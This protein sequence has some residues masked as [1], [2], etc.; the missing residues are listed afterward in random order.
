MITLDVIRKDMESQL[1]N[2]QMLQSVEVNADSLDEALADAAA[3]LDSRV[4][5]LEYEVLEKGSNGFLG[6][7]KKPW[8][9]R[10]YQNAAASEK[11]KKAAAASIFDDE[12][13]QEE[14]KIVDRD[15][16]YYIRH[17]KNDICI[18]VLLPIGTGRPV[19]SKSVI[20]DARRQDTISLD[21]A[22][23]KELSAAGTNDEY[24]VVGEYKNVKAGDA[25]LAV[26]ITKDEMLATITVT[27]PAMSGSELSREQILNALEV[28]GVTAGIEMDKID[29]FVD[30]PTYNIPC[31]VAAA[32]KPVDGR[33]AYIAFNFET[34]PTK[35][36]IKESKNGQV[37]FKEL[38]QI[39]N[40]VK[41]QPLA[42]KMPPER[43]KAGKTLTGRYLEAKDGKDVRLPLGRNVELD[44]DGVTIIASIN[45]RVVYEGDKINVEPV[46]ELDAV[47]IKSGNIDFLGTVIVKGNVEDG[48]DIKA[49]GNIEVMGTVGKSFLKSE[50]GD[51]I[52]SQGIFGH[53]VGVIQCGGSLWAKFIQSAKVEV[54]KNCVVSD[55]IMNSEVTAMK[56]IILN[57]KK[58]QITGGHLFATEEIAA[59][60][61]GSPGGGAETILGVGFD[62]RAKKRLEEIQDQQAALMKEL[63][64]IENNIASLEN[65]KKQ[66]RSLPKEKE[67]NLAKLK[68]RNQEITVESEKISEEIDQIQE[69]LH[70]LK[71]VGKVMASG[72]VYA[73][74]KVTIRDVTDDVRTD[75]KSV[76]FSYEGGFVRR[77]KYEAP[78][79]SDVGAPEGYS[80]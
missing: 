41:G 2:D 36:K 54:E 45:G 65:I 33:D 62:P 49:T 79:M 1:K 8:R 56:R 5:T 37:N 4:S 68:D 63:E 34:D 29:E 12:N 26:D 51:I 10:I 39:Q 43:G 31:E 78:D 17:F 77:G 44:S 25:M 19:D 61:I 69:R 18:K 46:M 71:A 48:Y 13:I 32:I 6:M 23:I 9:V 50:E 27:A 38:N 66:R 74:V 67:E 80:A 35:L 11:R 16:L 52:V 72:T 20:A 24:V 73:G 53:D 14:N 40:V 60:N 15:G 76:T 21:E 64:E 59:K 22:K 58:A 70:E 7:A 30:N 3:Q 42:Q 28:Q 75:V 47:N 57:G 55:S